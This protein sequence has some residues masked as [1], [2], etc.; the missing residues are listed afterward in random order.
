LTQRADT[1]NGALAIKDNGKVYKNSGAAGRLSMLF[2]GAAEALSDKTYF[3]TVPKGTQ[4]RL[5]R[6]T[7]IIKMYYNKV[8]S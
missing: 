4:C 5:K 3:V 7:A 6:P 2:I 8:Q 1:K